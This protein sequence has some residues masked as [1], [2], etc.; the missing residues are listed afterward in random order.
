[1]SRKSEAVQHFNEGFNC[2]KAVVSAFAADIAI[3]EKTRTCMMTPYRAL[4]GSPQGL[5]GVVAGGVRIIELSEK[6]KSRAMALVG[7]FKQRFLDKY[8][9]VACCDLLGCD[10]STYEGTFK[11]IEENLCATHCVRY[12]EDVVDMLEELLS[13]KPLEITP[14]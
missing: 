13:L 3:D 2:C 14:N 1:M 11:E 7:E 5:C 10:L 8:K 9:T 12:V 4:L 6:N